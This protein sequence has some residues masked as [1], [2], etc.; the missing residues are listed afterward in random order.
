MHFSVALMSS[1]YSTAFWL[2][3]N[4]NYSY[5]FYIL[6]ILSHGTVFLFDL[7]IQRFMFLMFPLGLT[8]RTFSSP[9][10]ALLAQTCPDIEF[11]R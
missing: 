11:T 8:T 4:V 9:N 3:M 6:K 10:I 2:S 1:S 7:E 5:F